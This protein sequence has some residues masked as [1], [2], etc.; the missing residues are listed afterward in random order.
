MGLCDYTE[1]K[2]YGLGLNEAAVQL[3]SCK[4]NNIPSEYV[5]YF[6]ISFNAVS[7]S[8]YPLECA[9]ASQMAYL[10]GEDIL[11][12][13]TINGTDDFK[14][15]F[16]SATSDKTFYTV[17]NY[18]DNILKFEEDIVKLTNKIAIADDRNKKV[19]NMIDKINILKDKIFS[20]FIEA[21]NL[22]ISSYFDKAFNK[23]TN[24]EEL[25]I[26]R[27]K[28]FGVKN[29]LG[30]SEGY[31]F[32]ND[33][34]TEKMSKL[35]HKYNVLENGGIETAIN[36][37]TKSESKFIA[38]FKFIKKIILGNSKKVESKD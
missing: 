9:I 28:L 3:M 31:T 14:D 22:I 11:F 1:F 8:Y 34:Y 15:A 7:P 35:E 29:Y 37:R 13:S 26:Y 30:F 38:L 33:Y 27:R 25:E 32:F 19:D 23:I 5:K 20:T 6:K 16:I 4:I 12:F 21:Q 2:T 18:I 24:L 10:V 36:I 17:Q